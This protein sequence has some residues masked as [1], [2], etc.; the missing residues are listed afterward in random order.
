M[1]LHD[2]G[3]LAARK[4]H[5][6]LD[7]SEGKEVVATSEG[8]EVVPRSE[9][10]DVV[11]IENLFGL[12]VDPASDPRDSGLGPKDNWALSSVSDHESSIPNGGLQAWIQV[13]GAFLFYF[14]SW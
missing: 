11:P 14:N 2:E 6:E 13:L 12:I 4:A 7:R 10:K 5:V 8:K 9:G 1:A 3:Q